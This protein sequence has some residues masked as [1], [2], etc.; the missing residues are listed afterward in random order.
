MKSKS[1]PGLRPGCPTKMGDQ[2]EET[3]T[4]GSGQALAAASGYL[5][6]GLCLW[7]QYLHEALGC[8]IPPYL[9]YKHRCLTILSKECFYRL[10][11]GKKKPQPLWPPE[12]N[13]TVRSLARMQNCANLFFENRGPPP[14]LGLS[15]FLW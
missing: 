7:K 5:R 8:Q 12:K 9:T 14:S 3:G 13:A 10:P 1:R 6:L 11:W 2:R 4:R 15:S